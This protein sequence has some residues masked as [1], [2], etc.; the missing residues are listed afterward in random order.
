MGL[1]VLDDKQSVPVESLNKKRGADVSLPLHSLEAVPGTAIFTEDPNAAAL[2]IYQNVDIHA[3]K[4]GTGRSSDIIL[5]P[6]R[7]SCLTILPYDPGA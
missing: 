1:G 7:E 5:V 3:L 4:K 2:A 6:Q